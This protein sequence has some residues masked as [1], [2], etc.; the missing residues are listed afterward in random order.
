MTEEK[1][2]SGDCLETYRDDYFSVYSEDGKCY[3]VDHHTGQSTPIMCADSTKK[4]FMEDHKM[5]VKEAKGKSIKPVYE[6]LCA[7]DLEDVFPQDY[8]Y[9]NIRVGNMCLQLVTFANLSK[10]ALAVISVLSGNCFN[11]ETQK[12]SRGVQARNYWYG[13]KQE[14]MQY[15]GVKVKKFSEAIKE[16]QANNLLVVI[17]ENK[18]FRG[19][20]FVKVHPHVAFRSCH[21][22]VLYRAAEQWNKDMY[23]NNYKEVT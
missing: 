21:D 9:G 12:F 11:H 15:S 19:G 8:R 22:S 16:L 14:I 6:C 17:K 5:A 1:D 10:N 23:T 18:P 3:S 4:V 2:Y 13:T 7:E 20:L